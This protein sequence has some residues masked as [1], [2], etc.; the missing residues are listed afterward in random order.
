MPIRC[1]R[2]INSTGVTTLWLDVRPIP[3]QEMN[4][5]EPVTGSSLALGVH[6]LALI[7]VAL[8]GS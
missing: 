1:I 6:I 3:H 4:A 7:Y 8:C 2:G 5:Q